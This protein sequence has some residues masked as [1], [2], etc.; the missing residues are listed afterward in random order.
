MPIQE[1]HFKVA[2]LLIGGLPVVKMAIYNNK[3]KIMNYE[4]PHITDIGEVRQ[5]CLNANAR[6]QAPCFAERNIGEG[7]IV[8]D[9]VVNVPGLFP[10]LTGDETIDRETKLVRECRGLIFDEKTGQVIARG[11]HKFFNVNERSEVLDYKVDMSQPYVIL[12]KLDGSMLRPI[13]PFDKRGAN[14]PIRW[15]TMRVGRQLQS[16]LMTL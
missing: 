13:R 6:V 8:F 10:D 15:G 9:Y 11:Y 16:M 2:F 7:Y 12:E 4:F 5:A 3:N 1:S 14:D